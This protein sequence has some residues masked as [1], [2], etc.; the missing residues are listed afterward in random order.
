VFTTALHWSLP[1]ARLIQSTPLHSISLRSIIILPTQLSP[2]LPC[3]FYPF[4]FPTNPTCI[5]L[6]PIPAIYPGHLLLD[7]I[8]LII[9]PFANKYKLWSCSSQ[10]FLYVTNMHALL[11]SGHLSWSQH[12]LN[13]SVLWD[14]TPCD[15]VEVNRRFWR[16]YHLHLQCWRISTARSQQA[17]S[18]DLLHFHPATRRYIPEERTLH[19]HSCESLRAYVSKYTVLTKRRGRAL[20]TPVS[21]SNGLG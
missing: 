1:W 20:A 15:R 8:I 6:F 13:N 5:P 4:D 3:G 7:M 11:C 9:G 18:T 10:M 2:G 21:Y 14:I 19:T 16:T 12:M 17:S